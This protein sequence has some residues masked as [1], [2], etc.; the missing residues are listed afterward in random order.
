MKA[1]REER[2]G[3]RN[4]DPASSGV[5]GLL[6]WI[7]IATAAQSALTWAVDPRDMNIKAT[8]LRRMEKGR[9]CREDHTMRACGSDSRIYPAFRCN[10]LPQES[11][12]RTRQT[13]QYRLVK[14]QMIIQCFSRGTQNN[15][16]PAAGNSGGAGPNAPLH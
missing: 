1:R 6:F 3:D 15:P 9:G 13:Q 8:R 16:P 14:L 5:F 11:G 10:L 12:N 2:N 4:D 7:T